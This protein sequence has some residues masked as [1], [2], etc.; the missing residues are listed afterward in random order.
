MDGLDVSEIS[1]RFGG[2]Q[3]LD[4]IS[5]RIE[6]GEIMGLIGPNGAGKTTLFNC[7]SRF[8]TPDSGAISFN[9]VDLLARHPHEVIRLGI[10]RTFQH[11]ELFPSMTVLEN[12]LVGQHT[13]GRGDLL[14]AAF[15]LPHVMREERRLR[16]RAREVLDFLGL[17]AYE[18]WTV[19][20][21]PYGIR[22]RVD[23]ARALVGRPRLLLLDEPAAGLSHEEMD[24]LTRLIRRMRDE[25][26]ATVL[27]VEHHMPL[28]MSISDRVT[29]L[30]YGQ[31]IAQG[32]P[33][34]VQA[35]PAVITAYLG[36]R[37]QRQ[38]AAARAEQETQ[39]EKE[40]VHA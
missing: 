2:L 28:V 29:V 16:E 7:I 25:F 27:L 39:P 22:K 1:I 23:F 21:L 11:L 17:A 9:G 3:A 40:A 15:R 33:A 10:G 18:R 36:T 26:D 34:E 8:Y 31:T 14:S 12:L 32:T 24:D 37:A 35:D 6:P 30:H 5:F 4:G 20:V 19:A 38:E 13:R